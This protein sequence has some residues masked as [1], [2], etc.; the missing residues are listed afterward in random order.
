[1]LKIGDFSKLSRVSIR[2]LRHYDEIDLLKPVKID[3][4]TGYRYYS[5]EQLP[6]M[7]RICSLKDMG[8]GLVVIKEI[9]QCY[10]SKDDLERYLRIKHTELTEASEENARRLRLLDTALDR[11]RKDETMK[12]DVVLKKLP[13]R[14]VASVRQVIPRYEEEGR[15]WHILFQETAPMKL[16]LA[17]PP[18]ISAILH[19]KEYKETDVDVEVQAAVKGEY[20]DTEHVRFK[21]ADEVEGASIT[22]RGSYEQFRDVYASLAEWVKTN[23]YV[24]SG[25]MIDIYYVG[26]HETQNPDEFI[27][28]ICCPVQKAQL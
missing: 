27:T 28:E 21:T 5:E 12:Y 23:G 16:V 25:P 22:F 3:K 7:A 26:P 14:K 20:T 1:M 24:F 4:F 10:E 19:D 6:I 2:M 17:E 18:F 13:E 15:L 11:L 9:L 8:F